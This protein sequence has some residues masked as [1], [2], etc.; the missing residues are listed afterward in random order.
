[1]KPLKILKSLFLPSDGEGLIKQADDIVERYA[2]GVTGKHAMIRELV[3]LGYGS[4]SS[5]RAHDQPQ[6][7]GVPIIDALVNGVN[8]II[9]P[10]VTIGLIGG[11]MGWWT[12][13]D[14]EELHPRYW[15]ALMLALG[16]WFGGRA[17]LKD[18]PAAIKYLKGLR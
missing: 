13:P 5:A 7:S 18:L 1:M 16:F 9:R 6:A 14:P 10:G 11:L 8:R 12:I 2:P 15:D 3:E 4:Q 17:L